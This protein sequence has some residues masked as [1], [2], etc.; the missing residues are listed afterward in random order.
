MKRATLVALLTVATIGLAGIFATNV[1]AHPGYGAPCVASGCH[2]AGDPRL[3]PTSPPEGLIP[4][5]TVDATCAVTVSNIVPSY[6]G[7]AMLHLSATDNVGGWG[8]GYIY[9]TLDGSPVRLIRVPV[10]WTNCMGSM[11]CE[12]SIPVSAPKTG[13]VAHTIS[14]WSQDNY[15]NV[16]KSTTKVFTVAAPPVSV[17]STSLSMNVNSTSLSLGHSAHFFGVMS[18]NVPSGTPIAFLVRKAGQTTWTRVG[19]YVRTYSAHSW[20][21]YYHPGTRGTYYFKVRFSATA[22]YLGST[23]RTVTVVW[24]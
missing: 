2:V 17:V 21:R 19:S 7:D 14:F 8:V 20:S 1:Y 5:T 10:D 3:N 12:A 22:T 9:Y 4:T 13:Q 11:S 15:G 16:E 23:S 24:K 6:S 18:P